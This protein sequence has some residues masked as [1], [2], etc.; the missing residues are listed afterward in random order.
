MTYRM[1][2]AGTLRAP[3]ASLSTRTG[4]VASIEVARYSS[5]LWPRHNHS[6]PAGTASLTTPSRS[7]TTPIAS[8]GTT[9]RSNSRQVKQW[10]MARPSIKMETNLIMFFPVAASP[11]T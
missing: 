8:A 10:A 9:W 5:R 3:N 6:A 1:P 4:N 11:R 7:T 2:S